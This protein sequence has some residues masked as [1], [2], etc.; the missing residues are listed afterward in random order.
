MWG[1]GGGGEKSSTNVT[2]NSPPEKK[3]KIIIVLL[4]CEADFVSLYIFSF[5]FFLSKCNN[6]ILK[7]K[8][9]HE[10]H[11]ETCCR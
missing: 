10:G 3:K 9:G 8:R 4:H 6:L 2:E 7:A 1:D 11:F 5:F